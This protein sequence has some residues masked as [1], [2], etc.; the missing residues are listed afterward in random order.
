M[1]EGQRIDRRIMDEAKGRSTC[2]KRTEE[3]VAN[4]QDLIVFVLEFSRNSEIQ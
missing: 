2:G 4:G 3:A 1:T